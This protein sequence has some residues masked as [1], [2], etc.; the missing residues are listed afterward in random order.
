MDSQGCALNLTAS[1][2]RSNTA[3]GSGGSLYFDGRASTQL[4]VADSDLSSNTAAG[5]GAGIYSQHGG[6][7]VRTSTLRAN[8]AARGGGV[9]VTGSIAPGQRWDLDR[10][11]LEGNTAQIGGGMHVADVM[12]TVEWLMGGSGAPFGLSGD[13]T[14]VF[15][16]GTGAVA[17]RELQVK[18]SPSQSTSTSN[19]VGNL[20]AVSLNEDVRLLLLSDGSDTSKGAVE[21]QDVSGNTFVRVGVTK[22]STLAPNFVTG[23]AIAN[24][25]ND[26]IYTFGLSSAVSPGYIAVSTFYSTVLY[27]VT[28]KAFYLLGDCGRGTYTSATNAVGVTGLAISPDETTLIREQRRGPA[29]PEDVHPRNRQQRYYYDVRAAGLGGGA[30]LQGGAGAGNLPGRPLPLRG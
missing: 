4:Q 10:V 18:T 28:T 23:F 12:H 21:A 9:Y 24:E 17:G 6:L 13:G 29:H 5:S 2:L 11:V 20:M 27:N 7:A 15:S 16:C 8:T 22:V 3:A 1:T 25:N 14:K 19:V 30:S 26:M